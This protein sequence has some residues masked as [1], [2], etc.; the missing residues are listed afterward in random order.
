MQDDYGYLW[1]VEQ[2]AW[3][4][5]YPER[6]L[7]DFFL[8]GLSPSEDFTRLSDGADVDY[9]ELDETGLLDVIHGPPTRRSDS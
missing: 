6:I 7:P 9:S 3:L 5:F 8:G 1:D 2:E 4:T